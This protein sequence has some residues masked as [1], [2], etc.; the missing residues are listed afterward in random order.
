MEK[1]YVCFSVCLCVCVCHS[2]AGGGKDL[3]K[4]S[5]ELKGRTHTQVVGREMG[6]WYWG[7]LA[8][9]GVQLEPLRL[10]QHMFPPFLLRLP[11]S[12]TFEKHFLLGKE[13][14]ENI[15]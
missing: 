7:A 1:A 9:G 5:A 10:T 8:D 13:C 15:F 11:L 2:R 14:Y 3:G 6:N 4:Q 12:S